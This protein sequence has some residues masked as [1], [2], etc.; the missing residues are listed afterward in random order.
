MVSELNAAKRLILKHFKL[1]IESLMLIAGL[2]TNFNYLRS[3][4]RCPASP[5]ARRSYSAESTLVFSPQRRPR[6]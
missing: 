1:V 2:T 3:V 4:S 6:T 5:E